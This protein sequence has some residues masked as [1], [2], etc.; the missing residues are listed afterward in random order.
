MKCQQCERPAIFHYRQAKGD[1]L[2][3]CL[4]CSHKLQSV[5][6]SQQSIRDRQWLQNA[7][8]M[9]HALDEMDA[10]IPVG[11]RMGRLPVPEIANAMSKGSVYNN[12]NVSNS[13]VG[14]LNTGDLA[15]IDAAITLT[16]GSDMEAVGHQLKALAQAILDTQELDAAHKDELIELLQS[17]SHEIVGQRKQSVMK[18]LLTSIEER[19]K[20]ANAVLQLCMGLAALI[21][22]MFG[23]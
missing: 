10:I 11:P 18:A 16:S 2:S 7:A 8:M 3:L 5:L 4:D 21:A 17:L 13:S 12:I 6:D 22:R 23:P 9:N 14:I 15:K 1:D 19:A 20:G